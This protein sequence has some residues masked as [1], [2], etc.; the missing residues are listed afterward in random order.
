[1]F[2]CFFLKKRPRLFSGFSKRVSPC[3]GFCFLL[4][5]VF[6]LFSLLFIWFGPSGNFPLC[7]GLVFFPQSEKFVWDCFFSPLL[8]ICVIYFLFFLFISFI[9]SFI[10]L[11]V[12]FVFLFVVY[13][14]TFKIFLCNIAHHT[15]THTLPQ[16][17]VRVCCVVV[18]VCVCV[19]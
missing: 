15:H 11:F 9:F 7:C 5:F 14:F 17:S 6:L 12:C 4:F 1:M 10:Y 19:F 13:K 8:P 3:F 2:F 16:L 18:F